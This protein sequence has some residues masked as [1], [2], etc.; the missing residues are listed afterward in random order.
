MSTLKVGTIQ[1]HAN[2]NNAISIDSAGQVS[3][4][5]SHLHQQWQ[6]TSN[7]SSN[8]TV[9]SPFA[10]S[11]ISSQTNAMVGP[12][13]SHSSG[14]FTF[15]KTGLYKVTCDMMG[16]NGNAAGGTQDNYINVRINL[17]T[18]SG[19][20]Y[21][22]IKELISGATGSVA[23]GHSGFVFINVTNASTFRVQFKTASIGSG[24]VIN[25][26]AANSFAYTSVSFERLTDA[27][28]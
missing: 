6:L 1:D 15:P 9:L 3:F 23:F 27:Q 21:T 8:D 22:I 17:S 26:N 4:P 12:S 25:G 2:G 5:N 13:M 19:S 7:V 28:S 10:L 11:T 24:S 18:D 16:I 20:S 14:I